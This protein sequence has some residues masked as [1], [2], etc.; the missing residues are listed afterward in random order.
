MITSLAGAVTKY[1]DKYICLCVCLS[2]RKDI[3]GTTR[4]LYQIFVR[5]KQWFHVKINYFKEF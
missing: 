5:V 1:C 4:D 2:V 3:S